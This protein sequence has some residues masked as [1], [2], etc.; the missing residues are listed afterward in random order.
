M[1][2]EDVEVDPPASVTQVQGL[3]KLQGSATTPDL[4][5]RGLNLGSHA[6]LPGTV[7]IEAYS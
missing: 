6:C 3:Q 5:S 1:V 4:C 2:E 7:R